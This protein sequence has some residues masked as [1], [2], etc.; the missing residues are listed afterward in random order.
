MSKVFAKSPLA[1]AIAAALYPAAATLAA[2]TKGD[3]LEEVIVTATR[4]EINLQVVPQSVTA[5]STDFI[6]KQALTNL[7]DLAKPAP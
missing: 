5:L 1:F 4:R 7:S 2:D 6:E 3:T